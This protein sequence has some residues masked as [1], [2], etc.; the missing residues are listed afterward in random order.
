MRFIEKVCIQWMQLAFGNQQ[1][2]SVEHRAL[3][4]TEEAIEAAQAAGLDRAVVHR[5][6][7]FM[8]DRAPGLLVQEI[9]GCWVTL[10]GLAHAHQANIYHTAPHDPIGLDPYAEREVLRVLAK[11]PKEFTARNAAKDAAGFRASDIA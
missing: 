5:L 9:G 6:V 8:Y 4:F 1:L 11:D 2:T 3:R 7:D 10:L